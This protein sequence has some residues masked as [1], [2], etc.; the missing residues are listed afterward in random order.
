M[1]ANSAGAGTK[2]NEVKAKSE[3]TVFVTALTRDFGLRIGPDKD[4][5]IKDGKLMF[6][7]GQVVEV[8]ESVLVHLEPYTGT[9]LNISTEKQDAQ[10][11]AATSKAKAEAEAAPKKSS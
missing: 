11:V 8:P 7:V 2:E 5:K 9:W 4:S 1:A 3:N 10:A 6:K